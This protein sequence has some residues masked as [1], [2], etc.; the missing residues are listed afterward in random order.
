MAELVVERVRDHAATL[1]GV[2]RRVTASVGVVT[3]LA[4]S[5]HAADILALADMTMYDAKEAGRDQVASSCPRATCRGPRTAARLQW[6]SRIEAALEHDR[7]ELHLQPIMNLA[8]DRIT[9]AEVLLRLR[10]DDEL[11]PPS[12]SSTS[13]SG[14]G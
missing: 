7:F 12:G 4:A 10:E 8:N 3:F 1:D 14:S 11:V 2:G 13:P 5:E 9:S 6:Q